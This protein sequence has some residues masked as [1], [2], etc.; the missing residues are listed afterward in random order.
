MMLGAPEDETIARAKPQ[1]GIGEITNA[2]LT[3]CLP[4][5]LLV[6]G[7]VG[8]RELNKCST[9]IA[10][11]IHE[12]RPSSLPLDCALDPSTLVLARSISPP[13]HHLHHPRMRLQ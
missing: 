7:V 13:P 5:F 12:F 1:L 10:N 2:V 11:A 9:V 4:A 6:L 8:V 3:A